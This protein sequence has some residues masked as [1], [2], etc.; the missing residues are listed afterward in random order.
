MVGFVE[1]RLSQLAQLLESELRVDNSV[2]ID[3]NSPYT[4]SLEQQEFSSLVIVALP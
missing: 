1:S 3:A 2:L 4:A